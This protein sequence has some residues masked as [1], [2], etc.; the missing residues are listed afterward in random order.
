MGRQVPIEDNPTGRQS[1]QRRR[2]DP[3]IAVGTDGTGLQTA[4]NENEEFHARAL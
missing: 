2:V 4:N 1:V 3:P